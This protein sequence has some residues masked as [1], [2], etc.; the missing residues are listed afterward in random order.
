MV[1]EQCF[2]T[3]NKNIDNNAEINIDKITKAYY[4]C[5][6]I[7]EINENNMIVPKNSYLEAI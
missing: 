3:Q 4:I 1:I 7:Y 2:Y 6:K 5:S